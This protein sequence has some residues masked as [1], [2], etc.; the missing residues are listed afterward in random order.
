MSKTD[1]YTQ[2]TQR[3]IAAIQAGQTKDK[4]VLPWHGQT[5]SLPQNHT[6]SK[7]YRGINIPMLW[8]SQMEQGFT[9]CKWASYKQWADA[10]CFVRKGQ[11]GTPI[12]YWGRIESEAEAEEGA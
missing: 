6:T 10:G 8:A 3:I 12:V 4:F 11:K 9:A 5:M 7:H 2:V 1:I